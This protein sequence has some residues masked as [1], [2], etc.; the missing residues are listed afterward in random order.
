MIQRKLPKQ[1]FQ[2]TSMMSQ[3][4]DEKLAK[5]TQT[6]DVKQLVTTTS[7]VK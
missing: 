2:P 3:F 1:F 4:E 5:L 7:G 6:C